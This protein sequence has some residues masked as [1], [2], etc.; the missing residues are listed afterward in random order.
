M[1]APPRTIVSL[2]SVEVA[3]GFLLFRIIL[4]VQATRIE[5]VEDMNSTILARELQHVYAGDCV[6][7]EFEA[8]RMHWSV[9]LCNH[10]KVRRRQRQRVRFLRQRRQHL[11]MKSGICSAIQCVVY[12]HKQISWKCSWH[13]CSRKVRISKPIDYRAVCSKFGDCSMFR[14]FPCLSF[15]QICFSKFLSKLL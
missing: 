12:W 13:L 15:F 9:R 4:Q 1:V 14:A 5:V 11:G 10:W 2:F 7:V 6:V 3:R 8:F